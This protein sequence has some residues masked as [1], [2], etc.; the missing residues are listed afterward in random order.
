MRRL[1]NGDGEVD[2]AVVVAVGLDEHGVAAD[3][4]MRSLGVED[5]LGVVIGVGKCHFMSAHFN[6]G[7]VAG[8]D[9]DVAT[10]ILNIDHGVGWNL[11]A[12]HLR[13]VVVL[14]QAE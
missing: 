9:A 13:V 1:G 2:A 5:F 11:R 7:P 8:S 10:G 6:V 4:D 14:G 3:G 12:E